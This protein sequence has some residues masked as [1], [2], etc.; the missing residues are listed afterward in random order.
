[1]KKQEANAAKITGANKGLTIFRF[2]AG[3]LLLL[4]AIV[5]S[6]YWAASAKRHAEEIGVQVQTGDSVFSYEQYEKVTIGMSYADVAALFGFA[7]ELAED[8]V[9]DDPALSMYIWRNRS[10]AVVQISF[11]ND[12]V[13]SKTQFGLEPGS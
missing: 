12:A 4:T 9:S 11:M 10:G 5:C 3:I 8:S 6:I 2:G 7:G 1:M 13:A